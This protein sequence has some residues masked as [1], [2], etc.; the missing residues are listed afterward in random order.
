[1]LKTIIN[2]LKIFIHWT[3]SFFQQKDRTK[4]GLHLAAEYGGH[5]FYTFP[6]VEQMPNERKDGFL[7]AY[8]FQYDLSMSDR[9]LIKY[10]QVIRQLTSNP[11]PDNLE[12]IQ[13]LTLYMEMQGTERTSSQNILALA[14]W[15]ILVDDEPI[16]S[17]GSYKHI[18]KDLIESDPAIE[19]FFLK[20]LNH[21]KSSLGISTKD[22]QGELKALRLMTRMENWLNKK[23]PITSQ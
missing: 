18:K 16:N 15:L 1:M 21:F 14:D 17:N 13:G 7:L 3:M 19:V 20:Q 6:N 11:T 10:A 4:N 8:K 5:K 9:D 12:H 23:S 2:K 22:M